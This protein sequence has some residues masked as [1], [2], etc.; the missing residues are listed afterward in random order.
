MTSE[1]AAELLPENF[2]KIMI[3]FKH[4]AHNHSPHSGSHHFESMEDF[5]L[6]RSTVPIFLT[7]SDT[8]KAFEYEFKDETGTFVE[9][10]VFQDGRAYVM[11]VTERGPGFH[12]RFPTEIPPA[13]TSLSVSLIVND[14]EPYLTYAQEAVEYYTGMVDEV[15]LFQWIGPD[16]HMAQAR[17]SAMALCKSSHLLVLDVDCRIPEPAIEEMINWYK[18]NASHGVMNI[19]TA[20]RDGNGMYFGAREVLMD[21]GYDERFKGFF[22]EDTEY[23]MNFS[24][25][26][27]VPVVYHVYGATME[28]HSRDYQAPI[29]R[30]NLELFREIYNRGAR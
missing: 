18:W 5:R 21:P 23:F 9:A 6:P 1:Q 14:V 28:P 22:Y 13:P 17:N 19:K 20:A 30:R 25:T 29:F 2:S 24:R 27:R 10:A 26:G 7:A 4:G 3:Q 11:Q 15:R 12:I 16:M 8:L